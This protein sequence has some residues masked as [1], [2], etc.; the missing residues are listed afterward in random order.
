M[1]GRWWFGAFELVAAKRRI[2]GKAAYRKKAKTGGDAAQA[3]DT[4]APAAGFAV[5]AQRRMQV[6][7]QF[8]ARSKTGKQ[9]KR[10]RPGAMP[11]LELIDY[12]A[13]TALSGFGG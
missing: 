2:E 8:F 6:R 12:L 4:R 1:F 11:G 10:S 7:S 9:Q 5:A 3:Q 13:T